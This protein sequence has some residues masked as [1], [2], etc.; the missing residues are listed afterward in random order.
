[1]D[2]VR[3]KSVLDDHLAGFVVIACGL[4]YAAHEFL[5]I[6]LHSVIDNSDDHL[7]MTARYLPPSGEID[8]VNP[9]C[10]VFPG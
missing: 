9:P 10:C 7:W 6:Y 3:L 8:C 4:E 1:M 2:L 5:V